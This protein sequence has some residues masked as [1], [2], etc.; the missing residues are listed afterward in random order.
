[1]RRTLGLLA[2][3]AAALVLSPAA[4]GSAAASHRG[5]APVV[6]FPA[7]HFTKLEVTV[8]DQTAFPG[9]PRSGS[10]QDWFLN[11]H[12]GTTFSQECRDELLTLRYAR[13]SHKPMRLRFANQRGVSVR[14]IDYGR[15]ASAP[16]YEPLY[17]ALENAGYVA[18]RNIRVAGYDARLTPDMG[19][20]LGRTKRLIEH[21]Y[22]QN[23]DR[24][25]Q[26]IGHSNGPL[27]AQYLL[28]HTSHA[29]RHRY[30]HGF[31]PIAGNLPGQ[32][33]LYSIVFTGLNIED[34]TYPTTPA[35]ARTSAD[36]YLTAPSS[37]MSAADPK[38]FGRSEVVVKDA[39]TGRSYTP[40]DWPRLLRDAHLR[41]LI[42]VAR[43]YIGFVKFA[44][45]AHFP[46]VDVHA[47]KGSGIPTVVGAVLPNLHVG[48][49]L[50]P[51]TATFFL[52]NGDVNQEQTTN[53]ATLVWRHMS[54]FRYRLTNHPG[55]D[56]FSL[57]SNPSVID[58]LLADASRPRSNCG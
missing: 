28:T 55:V 31:S 21:T 52:R 1:M 40:A 50:D 8:H 14:I 51:N 13:H 32:G 2:V 3:L 19:G 9:C 41:W 20:F 35:Q 10:F 56:H 34:F 33:S 23:G 4:G 25:V 43:H 15:P 18:G 46:D 54:C 44:D 30:I 12:Q 16:F 47:E 37:W 42:P 58:A 7:F 53:L 29:W 22:R 17:Q 38:V 36:M 45:P 26:L 39:A 11:P 57:P 24:P 5:L 27:Y 6:I 48:Q 49:V